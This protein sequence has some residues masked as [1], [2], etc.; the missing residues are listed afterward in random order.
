MSG[1]FICSSS[2]QS[3]LEMEVFSLQEVVSRLAS[4]LGFFQQSCAFFARDTGGPSFRKLYLGCTLRL[5]RPFCQLERF[6][7]GL[8]G[9]GLPTISSVA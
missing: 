2:P 9:F 6:K 3:Y 4:C 8:F 1:L 7:E 5:M